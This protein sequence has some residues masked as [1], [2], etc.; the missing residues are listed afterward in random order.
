MKSLLIAL[1][2]VGILVGT[3]IEA[4]ADPVQDLQAFQ[5]FFRKRFPDVPFDEFSNGLYAL[6]AAQEQRAQW[7]QI[8]QLPPYEFA[9]DRGQA[10]WEE[11]NLAS[12]FKNAGRNIAQHYPYWDESTKMVRTIVL[13]INE[14][15]KRKG[16]PTIDNLKNG[17]MAEVAAYMKSLS[18]GQRVK[19]AIPN[20]DARDAYEEG[21]SIFWARRGQLN[22]SCATCHVD[23]AGK[24]LGG[25]IVSAALGHGVGYPA[26]RSEWSELGT[27]H[28]RYA[29]CNLQVRAAPFK[30]QSRQYRRLQYYET[31]LQ[32]GLPLTAPSQRP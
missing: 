12:C 4:H 2:A 18:R 6:P 32:Q 30:A 5:D 13:D 24:Q 11:N 25:E 21:R 27:L 9:L 3:P 31:Y 15:L 8:M 19:I 26:Y 17:T 7:E 29:A 10:F 20:A 1:T 22:L 23:N 16:Q 14:C 28:W